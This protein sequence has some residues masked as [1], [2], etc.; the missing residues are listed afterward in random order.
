MNKITHAH[1]AML[2]LEQDT[3]VNITK[4]FIIIYLHIT[5]TLDT[6]LQLIITHTLVDITEVDTVMREDTVMEVDTVMDTIEK[7]ISRY[8]KVSTTK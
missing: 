7:Q 5:A 4:K 8:F 6:T 1:N 3:P 2:I